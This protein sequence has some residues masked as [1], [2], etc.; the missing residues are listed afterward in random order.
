MNFVIEFEVLNQSSD[1]SLTHGVGYSG[2]VTGPILHSRARDSKNLFF[3]DSYRVIDEIK[4]AADADIRA[5][6]PFSGGAFTLFYP[7]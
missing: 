4:V 3:D 5:L 2:L 1:I 6:Q 7:D